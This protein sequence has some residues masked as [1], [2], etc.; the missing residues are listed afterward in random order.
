MVSAPAASLRIQGYIN[1]NNALSVLFLWVPTA[2]LCF[3]GCGE[4]L[5]NE[6]T[7]FCGQSSGVHGPPL[8][9]LTIDARKLVQALLEGVEDAKGVLEADGLRH[10]SCLGASPRVRQIFLNSVRG[11][12]IRI[13]SSREDWMWSRKSSLRYIGCVRFCEGPLSWYLAPLACVR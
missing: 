6:G 11:R 13:G 7:G 1:D 9:Q 12:V 2:N 10:C 5:N 8:G 4:S 3:K